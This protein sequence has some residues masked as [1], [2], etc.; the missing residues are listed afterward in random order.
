MSEPDVTGPMEVVVLPSGPFAVTCDGK[1]PGWSFDQCS[2][3][4]TARSLACGFGVAGLALMKAAT[5]SGCAFDQAST[6][7]PWVGSAVTQPCASELWASAHW[8]TMP[9]APANLSA[10]NQVSTSGATAWPFFGPSA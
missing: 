2:K 1:A 4:V 5:A 6:N 10:W 8:A 7:A 3:K 9:L